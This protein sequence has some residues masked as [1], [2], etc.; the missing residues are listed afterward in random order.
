MTP[1]VFYNRSLSRK[2]LSFVI[3]LISKSHRPCLNCELARPGIILPHCSAP[4]L[5]DYNRTLQVPEVDLR[6][7]LRNCGNFVEEVPTQYNNIVSATW[8]FPN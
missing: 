8:Q 7:H 5:K 6:H 1:Q 4:W 3:L 2:E